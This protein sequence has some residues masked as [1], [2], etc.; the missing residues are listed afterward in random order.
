MK[1]VKFLKEIDKSNLAEA[2]GK[3][4]NLGEMVKA[5]LPVPDAFIVLANAY[6]HFLEATGIKERIFEIL[7]RTDISNPKDLQEKTAQIRKNIEETEMP[8][9]IKKEIVEAYKQL[10]KEFGKEE[11][12][13]AIRSSAT[14]E[15]VPE[16]S[17]AGQMLTILNVKGTSKLIGSVKKCWASLFTARA[18]FYRVQKGFEHEKVLI[19]IPVQKQ[20]GTLTKEEYLHG[21]FKAGVGFTIHPSTGDKTKILIEASW[22]QGESVVSGSVTPDTYVI[23]KE[24]G[25]VIEVHIGEKRTMRITDLKKGGLIEIETPENLRKIQCLTEDELHQLWELARKLEEHYKFPQDF[26]W[27]SE[28]GR[29]Y[30]LQTRPVT[31]FYEKKEEEV[32]VKAKPILKGLPASPGAVVGEVKI[33]LSLEDANK[34]MQKG[35]ILVTT[36][37]SPDWVPFMKIAGGIITSEGGMTA[38]AAIVSRE[39]GIPCIVGASKALEVLKDGMIITLDSRKGL[40]Y[41]GEIKEIIEREKKEELTPEEI[42]EIKK[43]KTKTKILMNL[44]VPEKIDEYK[45]LPFEGIG[46]MRIEF[47][48]A[49][50]IGEHP[51]YLLELGQEQKYIDKLAEGIAKV[52]KAIYPRFVVVR[53]SDFKTNEYRQLKGGEK[54]E[55]HED[56]PMLGFRGVSRYISPEFEQAFRLECKAI[57]KVR[58]EM[59]LDNVWVMLPFV[60]TT[61]E[62]EKC[63]KIMEEEGLK[64]GMKNFKVW[65]MIEVPS[66]VFLIE[67]FC[68]LGIDGVSLGSNDL[69]QLILGIDR[70]S[71]LLSKLGYFNEMDPAVLKA[72]KTVISTCK[73]HGISSSCCGQAPTTKPQFAK[74]LVECGVTSISVNPD[75][76][77]KAKKLVYEVEKQLSTR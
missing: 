65:L 52:A 41:E 68:K 61:W 75:T 47:I 13:V 62:V 42:E 50:Y 35:N 44:G 49:S 56:N 15:D 30:L 19:A 43:L 3:G 38:H 20:L 31:V 77:L 14:A 16:A 39:M 70:D 64:R 57:K 9:E 7:R 63:L 34:K 4:A 46:L 51:N 24:T 48:I 25:K 12:Y 72:V 6:K 66:S 27:A 73:K 58:D 59:S 11:E 40:V 74:F 28:N 54:Y 67:E 22:G 21:K 53:F 10:S 2:G 60:R 1:F 37:T 26:E 5:G 33:C 23:D 18:T 32:E 55:P 71:A 76:V 45:D 36:M 8:E 69:T 17:F 29:V